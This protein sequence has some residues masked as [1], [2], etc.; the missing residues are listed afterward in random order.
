V[1]KKDDTLRGVLLDISH[2]IADTE[3]IGAVNIRSIAAKAGV[4]TG[5]VYNYFSNKEE[6]LLALTEEYWSQTLLEMQAAAGGGSFCEQ[7][8]E[9]F[10]FLKKRI[11]QSAGKL[12]N[13]LG[14]IGTEGQARMTC[15]QSALETAF[16][17]RMEQDPGIRKD[18]WTE[19]FSKEQFARFLMVNT[20]T[21]LKADAPDISFLLE[22]I[23]RVLY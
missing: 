3:G 9:I 19:S 12:M 6:I 16:V 20:V 13:S 5:T 7:L 15:M 18:I 4:A 23:R 8:Q 10:A 21:L 2:R 11:E 17:E 14:N 1:R 22:I